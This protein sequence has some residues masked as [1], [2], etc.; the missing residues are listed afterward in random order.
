M[1]SRRSRFDDRRRR[2]LSPPSRR[3][4][5]DGDDR[6]DSRGRYRDDDR[7]DDKVR[8]HAERKRD[9]VDDDRSSH[10]PDSSL[11]DAASEAKQKAAEAAARLS[12]LLAKKKIDPLKATATNSS[13]SASGSLKYPGP[14][15]AA[16]P[17][18][19]TVMAPPMAVRDETM[20]EEGFYFKDIEVNDLRNRYLVLKEATLDDIRTKSGADIDVRGKYYP[21]KSMATDQHPPMY[22]HIASKTKKNMEAA[23][24]MVN[25]LINSE[26]APL[27][28]E[29]RF[30]KRGD[31]VERD[32]FGRR[33]WPEEKVYIGIE[34]VRGFQARAAIVGTGG[35]NVKY[36]Q[37]ETRTRIQLKGIGSSYEEVST[38][39]EADEPMFLHVTGPDVVE[40][41]RA[42]G[43]VEDLLVSVRERFE[44]F[45]RNGADR[46]HRD[47]DDRSYHSHGRDHRDSRSR[48]DTDRGYHRAHGSRDARSSS[49]GR[50]ASDSPAPAPPL[51]PPPPQFVSGGMPLPPSL[52]FSRFANPSGA[53]GPPPYVAPAPP[54]PREMDVYGS[55]DARQHESYRRDE[56]QRPP[57]PPPPPPAA[58]PPRP[59]APPGL[60]SKAF[61]PPFAYSTAPAQSRAP[62]PP[63]PPPPG[64]H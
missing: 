47:R 40:V 10:T 25:Q 36:I 2:S 6:E 35:Q 14:S 56:Y 43:M 39:R 52:D 53:S 3:D 1:S 22:L 63:P 24:G 41:Q 30:R 42:K 58:E 15:A 54:P 59:P 11:V 8:D 26:L 21:D 51:P 49:Y 45:K 62:L 19:A 37:N 16:L 60:P 33:K 32:E 12:A 46:D 5:S 17:I 28:D 20:D 55:R 29:R 38:G 9:D 48:D 50:D 23:V 64:A 31:D 13:S 18:P 34:P 61:A 7:R 27:V 4:Y 44:E 57:P